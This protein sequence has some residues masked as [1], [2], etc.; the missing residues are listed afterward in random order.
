MG[1]DIWS[2]GGKDVSCDEVESDWMNSSMRTIR[3]RLREP[4]SL[5]MSRAAPTVIAI[6]SRTAVIFSRTSRTTAFLD[7]LVAMPF[8]VCEEWPFNDAFALRESDS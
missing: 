5:K 6:T 8:G 1:V 2:S 4:S 3:E 7:L